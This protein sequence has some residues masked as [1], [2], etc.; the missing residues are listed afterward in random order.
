MN[1]LEVATLKS[2][3]D[4]S[5]LLSKSGKYADVWDP[6]TGQ[7]IARAPLCSEEEVNRAIQSAKNAFPAWADSPAMKR[8]QI[9]YKL[10]DLIDQHLDELTLLVCRENGKVWEEAQGDVIKAK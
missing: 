9:L 2:S 10:R 1:G 4:G 6:S 8:A 5:A 3:V 7:V